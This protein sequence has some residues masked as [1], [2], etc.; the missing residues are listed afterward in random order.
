MKL[1]LSVL[2]LAAEFASAQE[3]PTSSLRLLALGEL[4][5]FRQEIRDG[6]RR[7]LDPPEGS[8]PPRVLEVGQQPAAEKDAKP[9]AFRLQLSLPSQPAKVFPV[10]GKVK[11]RD[12]AKGDWAE[13]PCP[14]GA[15]V[16]AVLW[17]SADSWNKPE[18]LALPDL[19]ADHD[20][21]TF[22][23]VNVSAQTVGVVFGEK[24]YQ[25]QAGKVLSLTLPEKTKAASVSILM[26]GEGDR[27]MPCYS[28]L[29]ESKPGMATQYFVHRAD[30]EKPRRPIKVTPISG[31][32]ASP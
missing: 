11:L 32:L 16:L 29:A 21:R 12:P 30:G 23:F 18:V 14:A 20:P 4:P 26:A 24:R 13:V 31:P 10:D 17:R 28:G 5:P 9:P 1:Y 15:K 25:L 2:W 8:I 3:A 27:L 19:G 22:R 6:V 7:E